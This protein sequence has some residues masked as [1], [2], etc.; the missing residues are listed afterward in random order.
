MNEGIQQ[1]QTEFVVW[2]AGQM[3]LKNITQRKIAD[4]LCVTQGAVNYRMKKCNFSYPEMLIIFDHL[5]TS[6]EEQIKLLTI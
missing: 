5:Q 3:Y 2:L 4:W 1:K 6:K